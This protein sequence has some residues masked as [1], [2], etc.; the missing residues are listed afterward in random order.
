MSSLNRLVGSA[1]AWAACPPVSRSTRV[2]KGKS[3]QQARKAPQGSFILNIFSKL[4]YEIMI[5]LHSFQN[6]EQSVAEIGYAFESHSRL[7]DYCY[8]LGGPQAEYLSY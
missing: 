5:D 8:M 6:G 2:I 3:A 7:N 1:L 4:S